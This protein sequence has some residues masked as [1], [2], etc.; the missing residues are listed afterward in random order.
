MI[1]EALI[2]TPARPKIAGA[3]LPSGDDARRALE[4]SIQPGSP[5]EERAKA[6]RPKLGDIT[7]VFKRF[8]RHSD[9]KKPEKVLRLSTNYVE[10]LVDGSRSVDALRS[11]LTAT[12][13]SV[14]ADPDILAVYDDD[15]SILKVLTAAESPLDS[16]KVNT[17]YLIV[18]CRR[19][20]PA[21][22]IT[23]LAARVGCTPDTTVTIVTASWLRRDGAN[24]VAYGSLEQTLKDIVDCTQSAGG[25]L[26]ALLACSHH[27]VIVFEESG[28]AYLYR[29]ANGLQGS[30]HF[31][32]NFDDVAQFDA[33]V[34]GRSPGH[35]ALVLA[36]VVRQVASERSIGDLAPSLRLATAAATLHF[37]VG[38]D[39]THPF[40][41]AKSVLSLERRET[42]RACSDPHT[43][44]ER[45]YLVSSLAFDSDRSAASSWT[46][47]G[48]WRGVRTDAEVRKS[49]RQ[50][51]RRGPEA[52][53]T[54]D[55]VSD[56]G[57]RLWHPPAPIS[58][59]F[60][61]IGALKIFDAE[62]IQGYLALGK[63][64]R[65]YLDKSNQTKPLS[66]A[67]FGSRQRLRL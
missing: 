14:G 17:R 10:S 47:L 28:L 52:V 36:A 66:I 45:A 46:R 26:R 57:T 22:S 11:H 21:E 53:F 18:A 49:L 62:E 23:K 63:Q 19:D 51:V 64:I 56:T 15:G 16:A 48:A 31:C 67:V 2:D 59:P 27:V 39:E 33:R 65:A 42:L 12:L 38:F 25:S 41:T 40:E 6:L 30:F 50:L 55:L 61:K 29:T 7:A 58:C 4:R 34:Y 13:T 35:T 44:K 37:D 3:D 1:V 20:A 60:L 24:I 43:T 8:P 5:S 9:P 54:T 32:P